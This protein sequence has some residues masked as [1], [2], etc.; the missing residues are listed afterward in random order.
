MNECDY[1]GRTA[2][3][4]CVAEGHLDCTRFLLQVAK[5]HTNPQDRW[6]FT[7]KDEALRFGHANVLQLLEEHEDQN[8][9][10]VINE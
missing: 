9:L 8:G 10:E 3:H 1:D 7:P 4:V 5:V 2:L 6:G